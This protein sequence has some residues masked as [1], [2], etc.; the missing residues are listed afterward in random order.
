MFCIENPKPL[1][2]PTWKKDHNFPLNM[3]LSAP[4]GRPERKVL[5]DSPWK[6]D[7]KTPENAVRNA[8]FGKHIR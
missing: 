7:L 5:W 1:G 8:S 2:N 3:K 4:G 6:K